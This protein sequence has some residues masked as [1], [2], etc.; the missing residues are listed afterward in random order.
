[1]TKGSY[2]IQIARGYKNIYNRNNSSHVQEDIRLN[3]Y[4]VINMIQ[5]YM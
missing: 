5:L 4:V 2:N 3:Y 1:M